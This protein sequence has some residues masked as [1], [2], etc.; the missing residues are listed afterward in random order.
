VRRLGELGHEAR[1][2]TLA[3]VG[4]RA[5]ELS[6]RVTLESH[7]AETVEL[8]KA[9]AAER[10]VLVGH[11]YAGCVISGVADRVPSGSVRCS[12]WTRSSPRTATPAG[13]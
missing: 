7:V 11:S 13:P 12:T 9:T 5:D 1:A 10:V 6:G 4:D 3:G 8:V 2:V